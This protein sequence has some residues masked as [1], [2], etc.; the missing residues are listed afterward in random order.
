MMFL[1]V[2]LAW[3]VASL[4]TAVAGSVIQTQFNLAAIT[5]LGAPVSLADRQATTLADLAGFAPVFALIVA[6]GFLLAFP[7]AAVLSRARPA[8]RALLYALAGAAAVAAAILLMELVLPVTAIAAARS[9]AGVLA[10]A[11]SGAPGGWTFG[12]LAPLRARR[13]VA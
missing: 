6:G 1:R 11:A 12:A 4:V 7:V 3:L 13:R 5:S 2:A 10:L 9:P 8:R